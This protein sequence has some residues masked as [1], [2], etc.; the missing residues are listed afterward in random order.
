MVQKKGKQ[1]PFYCHRH[2]GDVWLSSGSQ[3]GYEHFCQL[4]MSGLY[5]ALFSF[6]LQFLLFYIPSVFHQN[7]KRAGTLKTRRKEK[8]PRPCSVCKGRE[9][10]VANPDV[11]TR[12]LYG[13][14]ACVLGGGGRWHA[15][16]GGQ[17]T[18]AS[19]PFAGGRGS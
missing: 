9:D 6:S 2:V 11:E 5:H 4:Y 13:K 12:T 10:L 7:R 18:S 16:A 14:C 15:M 1:N 8:W 3:P 17:R 19:L